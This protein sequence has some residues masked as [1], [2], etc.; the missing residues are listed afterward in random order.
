MDL[1]K[2]EERIREKTTI[3]PTTGCWLFRGYLSSYGYGRIC[4][5]WVNYYVHTISAVIYLDYNLLDK[6]HQINHKD[7]VC[8]NRN[9]WN[10]EHLY[11]GTQAENVQDTVVKGISGRPT[12]THCQNGHEFTPE[13]TYI[14][15]STGDRV[16]RT[17]KSERNRK[18]YEASKGL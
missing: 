15:E 7:N 11:V 17:C 8:P 14:R 13:N 2:I 18:R 4:V 10:P 9:C 16:C 1:K 12:Q 6:E 5:D 3:D